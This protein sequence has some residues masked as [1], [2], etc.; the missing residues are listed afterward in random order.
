MPS[1]LIFLWKIFVIFQNYKVPLY[2]LVNC[3][4][5][6]LDITTKCSTWLRCLTIKLDSLKATLFKLLWFHLLIMNLHGKNIHW[7]INSISTYKLSMKLKISLT[8]SIYCYALPKMLKSSLTFFEFL[9]TLQNMRLT[10]P[11]A[12]EIIVLRIL[13]SDWP[14]ALSTLFTKIF[15]NH[16]YQLSIYIAQNHTD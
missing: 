11:I 13:K 16:L 4:F 15:S 9:S 14:L 7:L 2:A 3:L 5:P 8:N 10:D 12:L 1:V 6:Y